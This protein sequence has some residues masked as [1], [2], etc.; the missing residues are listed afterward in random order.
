MPE[1][2]FLRRQLS[3]PASPPAPSTGDRLER[4]MDALNVP[5]ERRAAFRQRFERHSD[6]LER[7]RSVSPDEDPGGFDDA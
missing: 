6:L 2:K 1:R 3:A 4:Q 5:P 7:I